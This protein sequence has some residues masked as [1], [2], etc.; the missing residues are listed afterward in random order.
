VRRGELGRIYAFRARLPKELASYQRFVEELRPYKGGMFFEMAGHVLDLM[1]ALLG[2]PDAAT[3]F[4][5]HHHASP[6]AGYMD[7]GV[8]V[9]AYPHAWGI[10][11]VP[12]LEVAPHSRRIEVYGTEGAYVIPHL[13]SG[14][15]ANKEIQPIDVY[16]SGAADWK[17][18][19]LPA[20][21]LQISDLREFAACVAG[22]KAPDYSVEHDLAVQETLLRASDML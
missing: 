10:I 3:P 9:C 21:V 7:N 15:L 18:I 17:R 1:I 2:R 13:G 11:E 20:R 16:R 4:L 5:G 8:A 19:D 22:K 12:A 6:P 14:H